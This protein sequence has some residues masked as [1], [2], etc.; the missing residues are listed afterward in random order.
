M[1]DTLPVG[2]QKKQKSL[3]WGPVGYFSFI[4]RALFHGYIPGEHVQGGLYAIEGSVLSRLA[5]SGFLH[6]M[7]FGRC[8]MVWTEDVLL[9]LGVKAVGGIISPLNESLVA[10]PTHI[11]AVRPLNISSDRLNSLD[12]L[13]VHPVKPIDHDLRELLRNIRFSTLQ[14]TSKTLR[15]V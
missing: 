6:A 4:V 12:L 14:S 1:L 3:R 15:Q 8:G 11:Q 10:A 9:S 5:S 2:P 7:A 13:A